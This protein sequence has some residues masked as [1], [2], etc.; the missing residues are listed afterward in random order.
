[1][2]GDQSGGRV[3]RWPMYLQQGGRELGGGVL[4]P[5]SLVDDDIRKLP[6]L[7]ACAVLHDQLVGRHHHVEWR[8]EVAGGRVGVA[9]HFVF[10]E[11][12]AACH[13]APR[14]AG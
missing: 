7:E 13:V 5:M 10:K 8:V 6:L 14:E 4:H 9:A 3:C 12:L 2:C 11:L 1:M